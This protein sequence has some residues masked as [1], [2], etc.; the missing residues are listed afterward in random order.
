MCDASVKLLGNRFIACETR[1]STCHCRQLILAVDIVAGIQIV[2]GI[3]R[4]NIIKQ[5][6]IE[7]LI[8]TPHIPNGS[9]LCKMMSSKELR[10]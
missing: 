8:S 2:T 4:Q 6:F 3:I 1:E 5:E 10:K 9:V 7:P